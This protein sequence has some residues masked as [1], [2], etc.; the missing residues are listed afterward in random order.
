MLTSD[1]MARV[2]LGVPYATPP[3]GALRWQP[4]Q[5][6]LPWGPSAW[7]A[8]QDPPGCIQECIDGV[9][10]PNHICPAV[11]SEDCL[12]LNVWTPTTATPTSK[13]P[14]LMY[15]HGGCV[16]WGVHLGA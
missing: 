11:I 4:P 8:T 16:Q 7:N 1:G 6:V 9:T 12:F 10:E 2:F 15:I 3:V 13:L 5:P 14:V